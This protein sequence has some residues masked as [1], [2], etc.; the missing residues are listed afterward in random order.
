LAREHDLSRNLIRIWIAKC[1]SGEFDPDLEAATLLA[2]YE[3]H[4]R[5]P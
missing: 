5:A 3:A 2:D 4:S 1:E